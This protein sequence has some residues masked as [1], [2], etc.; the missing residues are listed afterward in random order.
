MPSLVPIGYELGTS[1]LS[2]LV[3]FAD[4]GV[5]IVDIGLRRMTGGTVNGEELKAGWQLRLWRRGR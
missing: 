2:T 3:S 1:R 4:L 5:E